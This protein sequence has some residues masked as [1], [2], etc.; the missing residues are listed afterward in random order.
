MKIKCMHPVYI[1]NP[2]LTDYLLRG[3]TTY[4]IGSNTGNIALSEVMLFYGEG[5]F[6]RR[7]LHIVKAYM[8]KE[9]FRKVISSEYHVLKSLSPRYKVSL[10]ETLRVPTTSVY[11]R[12]YNYSYDELDKAVFIDPK[13]GDTVPMLQICP[14]GHCELCDWSKKCH[15]SIRNML[16]AETSSSNPYF[17]TLTYNESSYKK[18]L[19]QDYRN[20]K[21]HTRE[22][23]GFF[24]RF[25]EALRNAGYKTDFRYFAVSEYG[26]E[27]GRLHY[28]FLLYNLDKRL[29]YRSIRDT[30]YPILSPNP[31]KGINGDERDNVPL[32][33]SFIALG[34]SRYLNTNGFVYCKEVEEDSIQVVSY[35]SKYLG[36]STERTKQL[37]S[38]G[39]GKQYI[40]DHK[41]DLQNSL[42]LCNDSF[43]YK[44]VE[45]PFYKYFL[46][47]LAPSPTE[48]IPKEVRDKMKS[49]LIKIDYT[50]HA[51]T[52]VHKNDAK[53]WLEFCLF[54][55]YYQSLFDEWSNWLKCYYRPSIHAE[56]LH[57][58][59]S[60]RKMIIDCFNT[61]YDI[62]TD[63]EKLSYTVDE[64]IV[65]NK[66]RKDFTDFCNSKNKDIDVIGEFYKILQKNEKYK[67]KQK[68]NQ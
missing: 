57:T 15:W 45:V 49:F 27:R 26:S 39:F 6:K 17:V 20:T 64:I 34:W 66:T 53:I 43:D 29:L 5:Y 44:G 55:E 24:K 50:L 68:D 67:D 19:E 8:C 7:A 23:Q 58:D 54:I 31:F 56:I 48:I 3:Y 36:K 11:Y 65:H 47:I 25:R 41:E 32:L 4:R 42:K 10:E 62:F 18:V 35:I 12:I 30:H 61:F 22:I 37:H 21:F 14:C 52:S 46:N 2:D 59:T 13:T 1:F 60:L 28:H 33:S 9:E 51:K 63:L 38:K 40:L 16:E